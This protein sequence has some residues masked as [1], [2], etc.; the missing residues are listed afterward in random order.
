MINRGFVRPNEARCKFVG[1]LWVFNFWF[2]ITVVTNLLLNEDNRGKLTQCMAWTLFAILYYCVSWMNEWISLWLD[3]TMNVRISFNFFSSIE[4]CKVCTQNIASALMG[5]VSVPKIR[6]DNAK[7]S[8]WKEWKV[9]VARCAQS[10]T[11]TWTCVRICFKLCKEKK[12]NAKRAR[13]ISLWE[14]LHIWVIEIPEM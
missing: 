5:S 3:G 1:D 7:L 8:L 2:F 14:I 9:T 12:E 13:Q 10:S 6:R 4:W 11:E